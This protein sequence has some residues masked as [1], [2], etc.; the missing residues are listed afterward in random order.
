MNVKFYLQKLKELKVKSPAKTTSREN[1]PSFKIPCLNSLNTLSPALASKLTLTVFSM[2]RRY[3]KRDEEHAFL[4]QGTPLSIHADN[5]EIAAWRWGSGPSVLL[6]HGWSGCAAQF[7]RMAA[8]IVSAGFSVVAFDQPGHGASPG[9]T[10]NLLKFNRALE[11]MDRFHGPFHAVIGHSLGGLSLAMV[12]A[13][14]GLSDRLVLINPIPSVAYAIESFS[15]IV[16]LPQNLSDSLWSTVRKRFGIIPDE[17]SFANLVDDIASDTLVIHEKHDRQIPWKLTEE[18]ASTWD[19]ATFETTEGLGHQRIL[20]DEKTIE[21]IVDYIGKP[22][23]DIRAQ[24]LSEYA[25]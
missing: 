4:E 5:R 25:L 13:E 2:P 16:N 12:A 11:A 10:S 20:S 23:V 14:N 7:H 19:S 1:H 9:T 6:V 18:W 17:T 8:Q 21:R 24:V 3:R 15:Q 22:R